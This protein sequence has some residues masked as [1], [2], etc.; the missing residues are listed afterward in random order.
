[1]AWLQVDFFSTSL[2]RQVPVNVLIPQ[3]MQFPG[4]PK[5]EPE[6]FKTLY[7]LHGYMGNHTDWLLNTQITEMSQQFNIAVVMPSGDNGFYVDQVKNGLLYSRY[8]SN[9][10]VDFTRRLLPLSRRR[11]DTFIG[12]LSMGGYGALYNG[13]KNP[14]V[15]GAIIA[16]S[17]A[18]LPPIVK[19]AADEPNMMGITKSYFRSLLGDDC[20]EKD[21][22]ASEYNP[23]VLAKSIIAEKK[24]L[25]NLYFACGYNDFLCHGSRA[26]H[27]ELA[28]MGFE[29]CY[30]EGPGTHEWAFWN[31]HLR[32]GLSRLIKLPE[33]PAGFANPFQSD[34]KDE[35][36]IPDDLK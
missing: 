27:N 25:P 22:D 14:E 19:S 20:F 28:S 7:L 34:F 16:L 33:I 24:P 9:E 36:Y 31:R 12:G 13:L 11:E 2:S 8:I 30:E 1:M 15:F 4:A 18:I 6:P 21:L 32:R 35:R 17:S 10:L 5:K 3:P 23:S 26:L 29:H